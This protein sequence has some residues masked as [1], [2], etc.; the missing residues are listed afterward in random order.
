MRLLWAEA[1]D[2]Y[3]TAI[4]FE[5]GGEMIG[6]VGALAEFKMSMGYP[7]PWFRASSRLEMHY[8]MEWSQIVRSPEEFR[9]SKQYAAAF[10]ARIP[11]ASRPRLE[12]PPCKTIEHNK[13]D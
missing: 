8:V 7:D 3:R 10:A 2:E 5:N 11:T 9:Q 1:I 6:G 12:P 4:V 13:G